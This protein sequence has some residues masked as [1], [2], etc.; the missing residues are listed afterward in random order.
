[1]ELKRIEAVIEGVELGALGGAEHARRAQALVGSLGAVEHPVDARAR[2]L[3]AHELFDR[4]EEVHVQ[5]GQRVDL[6]ELG[7]GGLGREAIRADE[8]A[9]DRA[10][11][12]L[13]QRAVIF[14][15][16]ARPRVKVM[17]SRQ[18]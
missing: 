3:F 13:D 11:L 4:L 9:H 7:I 8:V 16:H 18:Q 12:L 6:G 10:V 1:M 5:T 15:F 17:P 14:F 2:P